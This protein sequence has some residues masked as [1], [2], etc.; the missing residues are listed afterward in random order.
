MYII[1][2][3]LLTHKYKN[4]YFRNNLRLTFRYAIVNFVE[5]KRQHRGDQTHCLDLDNASA[6]IPLLLCW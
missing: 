1:Y 5:I 2:I 6:T 3:E 4:I